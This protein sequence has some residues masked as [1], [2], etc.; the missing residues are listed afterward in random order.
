MSAHAP[1]HTTM[2]AA[3]LGLA[4]LK[5]LRLLQV[6]TVFVGLYAASN[7]LTGLRSDIGKGVFAWE[8]AIPFVEISILPYLSI[9]ALFA[10][11]FYLCRGG[12]EL[13]QHCARLLLA[14][15]I[16]VVCY[17][18]FPLRFDF[19]RPEPIGATGA[20]FRWLWTIDLPF[21]RAPS[22][23]ISVLVILWARFI[24][25]LPARSRRLLHVWM[26]AI[27]VSVLTTYQHHVIDVVSGLIVGAVCLAVPSA[28]LGR[29]TV[30]QDRFRANPGPRKEDDVPGVHQIDTRSFG[31]RYILS[32]GLTPN[33]E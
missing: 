18:A 3:P 25:A 8:R 26:T 2:A 30:K 14:L 31:A 13:E 12:Q 22:L 4:R 19:V 10:A 24:A 17:A 23:H 32:P 15:L 27:A 33:A 28:W 29:L 21:N 5:A 1:S 20:V 7:Y 9:F 6:S 16:S 11:S